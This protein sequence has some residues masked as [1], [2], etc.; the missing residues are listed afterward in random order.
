M[1]TPFVDVFHGRLLEKC[2]QVFGAVNGRWVVN[3]VTDS[4]A[5]HGTPI[6]N[7]KLYKQWRDSGLMAGAGSY[8]E[9]LEEQGVRSDGTPINA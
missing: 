7:P 8:R 3:R 1:T 5:E 6:P 4:M 2:P 9:W